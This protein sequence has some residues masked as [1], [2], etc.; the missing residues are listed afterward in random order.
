MSVL[1]SFMVFSEI[2]MERVFWY[3]PENFWCFPCSSGIS[4]PDVMSE[5]DLVEW[6]R[7]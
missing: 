1:V 3:F 5:F 7:S 6:F 4:D 2:L